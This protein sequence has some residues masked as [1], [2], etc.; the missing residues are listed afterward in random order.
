M[1]NREQ[2][3]YHLATKLSGAKC[4]YENSCTNTTVVWT[5]FFLMGAVLRELVLPI[6]IFPLILVDTHVNIHIFVACVNTRGH[7]HTRYLVTHTLTRVGELPFSIAFSLR[8]TN[9]T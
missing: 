1:C 9:S 7:E 2:L 6:Y 5:H 4:H 8:T 3:Y